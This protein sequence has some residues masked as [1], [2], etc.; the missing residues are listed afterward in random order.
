MKTRNCPNCAAPYDA[1]LSK[2]P[3]CGTSYFDMSGLD[4][5]AGEPF[6]LKINNNGTVL[7]QLVRLTNASIAQESDSISIG[8]F[9]NPEL[10]RFITEIS[11]KTKLEFEAI[12]QEKNVIMTLVKEGG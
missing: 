11:V 12:P 5:S 8:S 10:L 9:S 2:C 7:T 4:I 3:Y 1:D 6:Y